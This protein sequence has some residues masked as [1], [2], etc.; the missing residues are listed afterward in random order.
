MDPLEAV[1]SITG[2]AGSRLWARARGG[3]GKKA[4]P[5]RSLCKVLNTP[6]AG[7]SWQPSAE[8]RG[9]SQCA[10][11]HSESLR[12]V[13][14]PCRHAAAVAWVARLRWRAQ[15]P[16]CESR[17]ARTPIRLAGQDVPGRD[18]RGW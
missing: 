3:G 10:A 17:A 12:S 8:A 5:P 14:S 6:G 18:E 4:Q 16:G 13:P 2:S 7:S 1:P 11:A 15:R 9:A